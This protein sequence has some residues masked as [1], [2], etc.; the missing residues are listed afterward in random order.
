MVTCIIRVEIRIQYN[1]NIVAVRINEQGLLM[2]GDVNF[3]VTNSRYPSMRTPNV[4]TLIYNDWDDYHYKTSYALHYTAKSGEVFEIGSV[5]IAFRGMAEGD[6]SYE[7]LP[8]KFAQLTEQFFSLGQSREYYEALGKLP[9]NIRKVTLKALRDI[10]AD[11]NIYVEMHNEK[12]FFS[13][14]L[15]DIPVRTVT[16][17]FR[18]I[19]SGHVPLTPYKF[20]Y[21]RHFDYKNIPTL[22]LEF[23]IDPESKPPTNVHVLIGAN[24][25]GKSMLLR[26]LV[27]IAGGLDDTQGRIVDEVALTVTSPTYVPF[28]NVVHIAYSAF[29][30]GDKPSAPINDVKIHAVGLSSNNSETLSDQFMESF[31]VCFKEPR[32][33]RWISAIRT[34]EKADPLLAD[35]ELSELLK[36]NSFDSELNFAQRFRSMSSGHKIAILTITRLI[37]LVEEQS[38]VLLDEPETHLHPPLL[39]AMTRAISDL[40]IDRNGVAIIATHSPVVLQEVPKSCVWRLQRTGDD[41]RAFRLETESFGESVS[42]L[43]SEVFHLDVRRTGYHEV[44]RELV[45][46]NGTVDSALGMLEGQLGNE[47][48]LVLSSLVYSKKED[49]V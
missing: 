26:D 24:G 41:L 40:V 2:V 15:R 46:K 30:K 31:K 13:S 22:E 43:T 27:S 8:K 37:E 4:F 25:V 42:K 14:I 33:N 1:D 17:Q 39:S 11:E 12:V 10:A 32:R 23:N 7:K 35:M 18:R 9:E 19:I 47:G 29:D 28:V 6:N 44:L 20:Y 21:T 45:D 16:T 5:K 48:R 3:V 34:L 49:H 38:L 36:S